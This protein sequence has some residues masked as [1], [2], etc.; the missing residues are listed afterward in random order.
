[1]LKQKEF[2]FYKIIDREIIPDKSYLMP[3]CFALLSCRKAFAINNPVASSS[4]ERKKLRR[5]NVSSAVLN[6]EREDLLKPIDHL[7]ESV[8]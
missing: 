1:M 5:N 6:F 2:F 7:S 8:R 4:D 3:N